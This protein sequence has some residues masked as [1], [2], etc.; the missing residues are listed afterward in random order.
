MSQQSRQITPAF[1]AFKE[2][3][4]RAVAD[5]PALLRLDCLNPGKAVKHDFNVQ[6]LDGL[7]VESVWRS[8]TGLAG[9]VHIYTAGVRQ[10]LG[11]LFWEFARR[12]WSLPK[13]VYPVYQMLADA[14]HVPYVEYST[15]PDFNIET[16]LRGDVVLL[17]FPLMP[18]GRDITA[19]ETDTVI[20]WLKADPK[21]LVVIDRVYDY[22]HGQEILKLIATNQVVVLHSLS[23]T[24]L[25]PQVM[26]RIA[27]PKQ[28]LSFSI[29]SGPNTQAAA[30][31]T[32]YAKFPAE[33]QS[34][35]RYRWSKLAEQIRAVVPNWTPPE[36]GYLSVAN[37]PHETLLAAGVLAVPGDVYNA[38][39]DISILSC[40]HETNAFNDTVEVD[41]YHVTVASNFA[42]GYDK[43]A[44]TYSKANIPEST[45]PDKFFLLP[46]KDL[47]IGLDK[48]HRLAQKTP[49]DRNIVLKTKV[50][51][52][53]LRQNLATGRG[54]YVE[55][56][57]IKLDRL[58]GDSVEEVYAESLR[59][60]NK[61]LLPWSQ[62]I[63]RSLSVLPIAQACQARCEFCFS[64]SSVSDDQKQGRVL[65]SVLEEA[66][67]AAQDR[68]VKRLVIT[69]GGEPTLLAHDRLLDIIRM[70][71]AYFGKVVM[72]SNGYQL[73]HM[74][75]DQRLRTLID[76]HDAGLNVLSI[77]RHS[78]DSN[79][80][81][82][83][84][85]TKSDLVEQTLG[86]HP[87]AFPNM[88]LRWVCV[89]QEAGVRDEAS[90]AKYLNWAAK[91]SAAEVCFKE[92]YVAATTESEYHDSGYNAWSAANQV[93]MS[94]V[95]DFLLSSGAKKAY[96]L[97]WGA[98]VYDLAW[99]GRNIRVAVYTEPSVFW[100]RANGICRSWNLMADGTCYANL[101]TTQSRIEIPGLTRTPLHMAD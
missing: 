94:V 73:G 26:G 68:G 45:F 86:N 17:T 46:A 2:K 32:K 20:E 21:R 101:E 81:I 13:D 41:R 9:Q 82:M 67:R 75:E 76:Y 22:T 14:E 29:G 37:V 51:L 7:D 44:K 11:L 58:M 69:G 52:H 91:T 84:V 79:E 56:N 63:P 65:M 70:G 33:Q 60:N 77:S 24:L 35:F 93:S 6:P 54:Q 88:R 96:E 92:L 59:L 31:M 4:A 100:E 57:W 95:R 34:I 48:A 72:I 23:K 62:V 27:A 74:S 36:I 99:Q 83:K 89:L 97:P 40:L 78:D 53:E 55:R 85:D 66:C 71:R 19:V 28:A 25:S 90:L 61:A 16:A 15:L 50:K 87:T 98:P 39:P 8:F 5:N 3:V 80:S 49:G 47:E 38:G 1:L 12:W 64:H 18:V 30:L 10:S 42:R 43:Y